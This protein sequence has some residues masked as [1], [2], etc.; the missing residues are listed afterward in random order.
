M[1]VSA[2]AVVGQ[3]GEA[4]PHAVELTGAILILALSIKP[5]WRFM[6]SRIFKPRPTGASLATTTT[7]VNAPEPCAGST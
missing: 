2:Q 1:G 5:V 7:T 6:R 4:I 3:A